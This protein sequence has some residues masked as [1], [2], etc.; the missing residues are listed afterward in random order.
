VTRLQS[1]PGAPSQRPQVVRLLV[2]AAVASAAVGTAVLFTG[3]FLFYAGGIRVS[4]RDPIVPLVVAAVSF[5]LA[6]RRAPMEPSVQ[7]VLAALSLSGQAPAWV[8]AC[9]ALV[10]LWFAAAFSTRAASGADA[11]GYMS[12]G[13]MLA[14][15]QARIEQPLSRDVSWPNPELTFSPLGYRPAPVSGAIV[16]TYPPGLPAILAAA[17]RLGGEPLAYLVVP[18]FAAAAIWLTFCLGR[19]A[20][21]D[22]GGALAAVLLA[23]SPSFVFQ[24]VQPMADV[25]ATTLWLGALLLAARGTPRSALAAGFVSAAALL[26]RPN[27]VL[28]GPAA[29]LLATAAAPAKRQLTFFGYCA[30]IL[31]GLISIAT[32]NAVWYGS[33]FQSGYGSATDLYSLASIPINAARYTHW[34]LDTE[35]GIPLLAL[36]A[37]LVMRTERRMVLPL[38]IFSGLVLAS[39]LPY[40]VF[41]E[42][43]YL[44]F[45]LPGLAVALLLS[46]MSLERMTAMLPIPVS[47]SSALL[48]VAVLAAAC[49]LARS[50]EARQA[51][52]LGRL[53]RRYV[54][55]GHWIQGS[56][57]LSA[58]ILAVQHS[59]SV[60]YYSGRATVRWDHLD[61]AWLDRSLDEL[62]RLGLTPY[63]LLESWEE[64]QFKERF[65]AASAHGRLDWPPTALFVTRVPV[66]LYDPADRARYLAGSTVHP[67]RIY[68]TAR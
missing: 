8:A 19:R 5:L 62:G 63:L 31:P 44:R 66:R 49:L 27:L 64:P 24:S 21:S 56:L 2:I 48:S 4:A 23:A 14:R 37:P 55:A 60:R 33:P 53:E 65:S 17:L 59:G 58:V 15:G 32:I 51:I 28:L 52:E 30:G 38:L 47:V 39:Y 36:A 9:A 11:Y 42:W 26:T 54:T 22:R 12:Q 46:L 68:E 29:A 1:A 6:W 57:P 43:T 61:P 50:G 67:R 34:L 35:L 10:I 3:G 18:T 45:L 40:A 7:R 16:P 20:G 41:E 25:P 13:V